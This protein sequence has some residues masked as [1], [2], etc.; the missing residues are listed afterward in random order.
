MFHPL[1]VYIG[2]RY[3]R[4]RRRGFFV[5]FISWVSMLGVCLGVAAL[6]VILSV[7]NGFEAE[8]R[9]RLLN[10]SSH[11]TLSG[12]PQQL[13]HWQQLAE[14]VRQ[15]PGVVGVAPY[16]ELQ[17][18]VGRN[19]MLTGVKLRGVLPDQEPQV[20][21][22]DSHMVSGKLDTL[23]AGAQY[24][25]LGAGLAWQLQAQVGDEVTVL[26][27]E[28][29]AGTTELRPRLQSFIIGGIFEFGAQE[30][31]SSLV[32]LHMADAAA[33]A[34]T[35]GAP[36]GLRLKFSDIFAAPEQVRQI[37]QMLGSQLASS[38]WTQENAGY[39][40]AVRIEKTMMAVMLMLIVAIAAF[41]IVAAL[42]MVVNE[43]RT[44]IAILRTVGLSPRQ[45]IAVFITQGL[46]IGWVGILA[47]LALGLSL[48]LNVSRIVPWIE[49]SFGVHFFDPTVYY[50]TQIPSEVHALQV[51]W[52]ALIALVLTALATIYPARRGASVEP[53]EALRY[54]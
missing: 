41:N 33:L 50:I 14:R 17:G 31:D 20:S 38:D 12:S 3:V 29:L 8:L 51:F 37:N 2:L 18:M 28:T 46:L 32:L 10:L 27:P 13:S 39:F 53:A 4:T 30:Q 34:G 49:H 15:V 25:L 44:D 1:P 23:K 52:V 6:I 26:I 5:S 9:S 19:G 11:A 35:E 40:R 54:E 21:D 45:V 48:A 42:V 43:K 36:N 22:I 7:M 47:G 16:I 24:L